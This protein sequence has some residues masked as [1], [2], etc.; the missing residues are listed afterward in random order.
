MIDVTDSRAR[1]GDKVVIFG[2]ES[3]ELSALAKMANTIEYECLC[4][5]TSRV[6]RIYV[7]CRGE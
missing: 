3:A 4:L 1:V 7:D 2:G 5:V 6:P